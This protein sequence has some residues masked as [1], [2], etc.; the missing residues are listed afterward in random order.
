MELSSSA[1][2][3]EPHQN[4]AEMNFMSHREISYKV[5]KEINH[6]ALAVENS[7]GEK[8]RN[9]KSLLWKPQKLFYE[10]TK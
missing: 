6:Q 9:L 5:R 3:S 2:L 7:T 8:I 10:Q 4:F 1:A